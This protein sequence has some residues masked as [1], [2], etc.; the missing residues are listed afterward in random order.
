LYMLGAFM[1][2][3]D[4]SLGVT[5]FRAGRLHGALFSTEIYTRGCHWLPPPARLKRACV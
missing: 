1:P 5:Q 3:D 2:Y 4:V